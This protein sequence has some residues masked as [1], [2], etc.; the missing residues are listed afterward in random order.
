MKLK[1]TLS[2]SEE[3][4]LDAVTSEHRCTMSHSRKDVK[5]ICHCTSQRP[6]MTGMDSNWSPGH[7][8]GFTLWFLDCFSR[9]LTEATEKTSFSI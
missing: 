7:T 5:G 9:Y 3:G 2:P 1:M 6:G 4:K 8:H